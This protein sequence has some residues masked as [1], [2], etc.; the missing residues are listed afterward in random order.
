VKE[1]DAFLPTA[2][3]IAVIRRAYAGPVDAAAVVNAEDKQP[4]DS[5]PLLRPRTGKETDRNGGKDKR[6]H[7]GLHVEA[8]ATY[9]SA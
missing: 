9:R 5:T 7:I 1:E 6:L 2:K 3:R 4:F 8:G